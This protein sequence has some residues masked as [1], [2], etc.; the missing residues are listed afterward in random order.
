M[1][2]D[3]ETALCVMVGSG[4]A[5]NFRNLADVRPFALRERLRARKPQARK[6]K[7]QDKLSPV[8]PQSRL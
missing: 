4:K 7:T 8:G 6:S 3:S 5:F 1:S 2:I